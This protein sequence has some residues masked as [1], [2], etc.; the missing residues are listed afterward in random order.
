MV[1]GLPCYYGAREDAILYL[2]SQLKGANSGS[3]DF[4]P[5]ETNVTQLLSIYVQSRFLPIL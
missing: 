5:L 1:S 4:V 3:S 2:K